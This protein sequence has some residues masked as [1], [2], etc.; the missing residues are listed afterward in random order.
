MRKLS[1][2]SFPSAFCPGPH[3]G[4]NPM[5]QALTDF[6]SRGLHKKDLTRKL[7]CRS[8]SHKSIS[9]KSPTHSTSHLQFPLCI[10]IRLLSAS[11]QSMGCHSELQIKHWTPRLKNSFLCWIGSG[12][13]SYLFLVSIHER[14]CV[15]I[16]FPI[17]EKR[18]PV[19]P[20]CIVCS[21]PLT[22]GSTF[23]RVQNGGRFTCRLFSGRHAD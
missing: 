22:S 10:V 19:A 17:M 13:W 12:H 20:L 14:W 23:T 1:S 8:E 4:R 11:R 15:E 21:W 2:N 3:A 7:F 18:L 9:N 5:N 16:R 6:D